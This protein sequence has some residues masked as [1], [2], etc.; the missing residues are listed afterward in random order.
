VS[1]A[2]AEKVPY[3]R[4]AQDEPKGLFF[5][6]SRLGWSGQMAEQQRLLGDAYLPFELIE[7]ASCRSDGRF[8]RRSLRYRHRAWRS[9]A[10]RFWS[11]G[12][13]GALSGEPS[14]HR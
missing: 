11:L 9:S 12:H 4:V 10:G 1:S 7:T 14:V 3:Q 2:R 6:V 8:A 5:G 13:F